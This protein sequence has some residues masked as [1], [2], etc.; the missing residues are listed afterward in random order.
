V[1]Q[2]FDVASMNYSKILNLV[3]KIRDFELLV[4]ECIF[5]FDYYK[6]NYFYI[7][8]YNEYFSQ[9]P[10]QIRNPH[11]LFN[12]QLHADDRELVKQIH[13][14]VFKYF[15]TIDIIKRKDILL[16][17]NCRMKTNT[18]EYKMTN[19]SIK[20]LATDSRGNIWLVMYI[21]KKAHS[22]NYIIPYLK[23]SEIKDK[24]MYNFNNSYH[25]FND[26]EKEITNLLFGDKTNIEIVKITNKSLKTV[27]RHIANMY[28]K[29]GV[30]NKYGFQISLLID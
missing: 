9:I 27:K 6:H 22:S 15:F 24:L 4:K 18:G 12:S 19:V 2:N 13:D 11:L 29:Q 25:L 26:A 1:H 23:V 10:K 30:T 7:N 16:Y 17:F 21:I 5:I 3:G 20:L 14:R 8:S 28:E